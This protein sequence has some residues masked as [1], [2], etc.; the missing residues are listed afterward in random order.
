MMAVATVPTGSRTIRNANKLR[1]TLASPYAFN[2]HWVQL[3][4]HVE[5]EI[6]MSL[7]RMFTDLPPFASVKTLGQKRKR[8]EDVEG[9]DENRAIV[10]ALRSLMVVG[11]NQVTKCLETGQLEAVVLNK[12][13]SAEAVLTDHLKVLSAT[14]NTPVCVLPEMRER[15]RKP[16]NIHCVSVIGFKKTSQCPA[17]LTEATFQ[18]IVRLVQRIREVTSIIV[19]P[20]LHTEDELMRKVGELTERVFPNGVNKLTSE[21]MPGV[22]IVSNDSKKRKLDD[23]S[24]PAKKVKVDHVLES[25]FAAE[26]AT[27]SKESRNATRSIKQSMKYHTANIMHIIKGDKTKKKLRKKDARK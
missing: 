12:P 8:G 10:K 11:I 26:E 19:L 14:R 16:M 20:W 6:L 1:N 7:E 27:V 9:D 3:P 24:E 18:N 13:N 5:S 4:N 23:G 2:I 15:L 22:K 25:P 17:N 21:E